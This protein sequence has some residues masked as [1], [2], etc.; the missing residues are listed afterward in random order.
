MAFEDS[1]QKRP[2]KGKGKEPD[3]VDYR[4]Q[5]P[6]GLTDAHTDVT[7]EDEETRIQLLNILQGEVNELQQATIEA[8][9]AKEK[10]N[11]IRREKR[12]QQKLLREEELRLGAQYAARASAANQEMIDRITSSRPNGVGSHNLPA[13]PTT[14]PTAHAHQ[15]PSGPA[16][17]NVTRPSNEPMFPS[18]P[19]SAPKPPRTEVPIRE[20]LCSLCD[21]RHGVN[22]CSAVQSLDNLKVW[23]LKLLKTK[24]S[25][26]KVSINSGRRDMVFSSFLQMLALQCLDEAIAKEEKEQARAAFQQQPRPAAS[27]TST[28]TSAASVTRPIASNGTSSAASGQQNKP[29]NAPFLQNRPSHTPSTSYSQ[30]YS[31]PSAEASSSRENGFASQSTM[32]KRPSDGPIPNERPSKKVNVGGTMP[33]LCVLCNQP[34]HTVVDCKLM[35]A[36]AAR[37]KQ[38]LDQLEA[39]RN[40]AAQ[41]AIQ[42][43]KLQYNTKLKQA[44]RPPTKYIEISD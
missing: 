21:K 39:N 23:R 38:R 40:P 16:N 43:L 37:M 7:S 27:Y 25:E 18:A 31:M 32:K 9:E 20:P 42:A 17:D 22:E 14:L 4:E 30:I 33:A 1:P 35:S 24:D 11:R 8:I 34:F 19:A 2:T 44:A 28:N 13:G 10:K 15:M 26:D 6:G 36:D 29:V 5:D 3:D 41:P 12:A